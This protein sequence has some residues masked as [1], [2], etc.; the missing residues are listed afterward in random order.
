MQITI[1]VG[2]VTGN[3]DHVAQSLAM[4]A[5]TLA[6]DI[7]VLPMDGLGIEAF[8]RPGVFLV[9][10]S[11]TGV[12]D[13]PDNAQALYHALDAQARYLG[14][15]GYGL[16]AL[17]DSSYVDSFC[18]GGKRF[19]ERL[20]DLGAKRLG[21]ICTLDASTTTQPEADALLWAQQWRNQLPKNLYE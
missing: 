17:G 3:A 16:I 13:L 4:S 10:T 12:G 19:D 6:A 15:V 1:L 18:G 21:D 2:T 11:T 20:Q 9:C 5:D 7:T 14:H 8:D